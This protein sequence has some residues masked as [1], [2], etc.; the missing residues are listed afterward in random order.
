MPRS[1]RTVAAVVSVA[2]A[3]VL[4]LPAPALA[5]SRADARAPSRAASPAARVAWTLIGG[6]IGFGAG[7][8]LGFSKFDD[9]TYAERKIMTTALIGAAIGGVAG[10]VLSKDVRPSFVPRRPPAFD[11]PIAGPRLS[12]GSDPHLRT[13]VEAANRRAF[14]TGGPATAPPPARAV[15][16]AAPPAVMKTVK[17]DPLW[18]GMI[19]GAVIGAVVGG[20]IIPATSCNTKTNPECPA[21]VGLIVGIP[22]TAAGAGLGALVDKLR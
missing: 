1:H 15:P 5:Q 9:A 3:T 10:A 6:G 7:L 12:I 17:D 16:P 14:A 18:E 2:L 11:E 22:L 8:L 19:A 13:R 4:A 20:I 21:I